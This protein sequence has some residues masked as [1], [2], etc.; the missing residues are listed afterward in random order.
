[1]IWSGTDICP[2]RRRASSTA[3]AST[4]RTSRRRDIGLIRIRSCW[5]RTPAALAVR[6]AGPIRCSVTAWDDSQ[7]DLSFDRR[8]NARYA[9]LAKVIDTAFTWGDDRAPRTPWQ[10]TLIYELHVKGFTKTHPEVPEAFRG[11]YAG[12]G[13]EPVLRHLQELGVTAVELLP[14]HY[15]LNDRHLVE[16][17]LTNYWGYNT[18]NFFAPENEYVVGRFTVGCGHASSKPW[19]ATCTR[20]ASK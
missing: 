9:P 20:P 16:R 4:A 2:T 7:A 11:S 18:L 14:V 17:G 13:T 12:L 6:C 8:D 10:K 19:S 3:F 1:M 5:T 15:H